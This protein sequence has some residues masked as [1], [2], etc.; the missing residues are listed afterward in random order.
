[1]WKTVVCRDFNGL[2]ILTGGRDIP[3]G[4]NLLCFFRIPN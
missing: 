1:M 4:S 3:K 2:D